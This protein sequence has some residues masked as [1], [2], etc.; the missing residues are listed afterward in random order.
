MNYMKYAVIV[1]LIVSFS[2]CGCGSKNVS[3]MEGAWKLAHE[4]QKSGDTVV[5]EFPLSITGSE[6][7]VWSG[8]SFVFVGRFTQDSVTS[9]AFG[10][11][12]FN[13]ENGVY[14]ETI[15]FHS[16]P[17]FLGKKMKIKIDVT[18][19]TITQYFPLDENGQVNMKEYYVE[20]WVRIR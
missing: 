10:G 19:D 20:K 9:D 11:G 5:A 8:K 1:S 15:E 4:Y 18:P 13:Y 7:K 6:M 3:P 16:S 14:E 17:D 2:L 12:S